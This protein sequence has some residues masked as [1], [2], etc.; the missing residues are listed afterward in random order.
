MAVLKNFTTLESLA[1]EDCGVSDAGLAQLKDLPI[2]DLALVRCFSIG[3][4]GLEHVKR[5]RLRQLLLRDTSVTGEGLVHLAGMTTL[6]S[7]T[8][9]R[10]GVDD[11]GSNVSPG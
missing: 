5:F 11:A 3:D 10:C 8:L 1:I 2:E 7:L 6:R 9:S 4:K